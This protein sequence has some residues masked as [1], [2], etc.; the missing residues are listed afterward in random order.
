M[1][2]E[3][4][5]KAA[6]PVPEDPHK[7]EIEKARKLQE[8]A[9]R[10]AVG[11]KNSILEKA[12]YTPDDGTAL[13]IDSYFVLARDYTTHRDPVFYYFV[14]EGDRKGNYFFGKKAEY[15]INPIGTL[16][17]EN[18]KQ[19]LARDKVLVKGYGF[20]FSHL[21]NPQTAIAHFPVIAQF[22]SHDTFRG[23]H[24]HFCLN[25]ARYNGSWFDYSQDLVV[26]Y[27][28]DSSF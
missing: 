9:E 12:K 3:D 20:M 25:E 16:F 11:I 14:D 2:F 26:L 10:V 17:L 22:V 5:I 23:H 27:T 13:K 15:K 6:R 8:F 21:G 7:K 4:E 19:I 24:Y 1:S 28:Y 18:L